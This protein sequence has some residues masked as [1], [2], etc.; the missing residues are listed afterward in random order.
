MTESN[1]AEKKCIPCQG[2]IPPIE[3]EEREKLLGQL[4]DWEVIDGH[5]LSKSYSFKGFAPALEWV[6][7]IGA[8]AEDEGHHP[9]LLLRWGEVRVDMW[10][11]KIDGLTESDFIFAAKIDA[12]S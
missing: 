7:K 8:L 6:N 9:D 3:Q 12:L 5:H 11:H 2:G 10:T 4:A 1:L